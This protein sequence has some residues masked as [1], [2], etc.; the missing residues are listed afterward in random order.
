MMSI[1][2]TALFHAIFQRNRVKHFY[3][4]KDSNRYIRVDGERKAWELGECVKQ[5]Y[6]DENPPSR[7]NLRFFVRLRNHIEHRFLPAIDLAIYGECQALLM[8]YERLLVNEFGEDFSL[9]AS[10]AI[11]VQMLSTIPDWRREVLREIQSREYRV[12][13]NFIDAYRSS[14]DDAVWEGSEYSFRVFLV[15]KIGN[16]EGTSD[17]AVEFVPYNPSDPEQMKKYERAVALIRTRHVPV[18]HP[19]GLKPADVCKRIENEIGVKMHPS[20]HHA[21][22]WKHFNVRPPSGAID[23]ARTEVKYCQYDDAHRDYVY[24]EEWVEL[25]INEL[26]NEEKRQKILGF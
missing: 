21:Y 24:T 6:E 2:W 25:L 14:L 20:S 18:V 7:E 5:Y 10:L 12:V 1:A 26:S 17:V 11:P 19:G 8:N 15:P 23:P 22:C 13:K 16:R 3:R 4:K 9:A